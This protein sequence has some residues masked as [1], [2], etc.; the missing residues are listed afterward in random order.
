MG[1]LCYFMGGNWNILF[2]DWWDVFI[3]MM[4][5]FLGVVKLLRERE[6]SNIFMV[7]NN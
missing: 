5:C 3:G 4:D 6:K 2:W 1:G 7:S